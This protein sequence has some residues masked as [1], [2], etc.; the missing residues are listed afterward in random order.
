MRMSPSDI[1]TLL[2]KAKREQQ[3]A[4]HARFVEALVTKISVPAENRKQK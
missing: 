2:N 1:D 4:S 3:L